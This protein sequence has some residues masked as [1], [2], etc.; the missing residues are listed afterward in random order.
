MSLF[1]TR[2]MSIDN[3][4]IVFNSQKSSNDLD[5]ILQP[6]IIGIYLDLVIIR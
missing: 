3:I 6:K 1:H 4:N 2:R 5:T